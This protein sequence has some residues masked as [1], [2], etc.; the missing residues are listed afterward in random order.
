MPGNTCHDRAV[1]VRGTCP[2]CGQERALPGRRPGD[3]ALICTDCAG[4][5][6]SVACSR[7]GCEDKLHRGRLCSRCTLADQVSA[8]LDDGSGQIRPALVPLA[9]SLLA[10]DRPRS[11]LGWLS[12]RK[13]QPG[14]AHDLLRRLGRGEIELTHEAFL[15]L[16][17]PQAATHLRE[18]LMACGVLPPL[19]R[20]VW[21]FEQWLPGHLAALPDQGHAQLIR[22][23]ATWDVLPRLRAGAERKPLTPATRRYAGEQVKAATAFLQ[24]LAGRDTAPASCRQADIDAWYADD[25]RP[26]RALVRNFVKWCIATRLTGRLRLPSTITRHAAPLSDEER[27]FH[28]GRVLTDEDLPLRTRIASVFLLLYAQPCSR[29]VRL[30]LDD[31]TRDGDQ[32]LLRLGDPPVPL[33]G[34]VASL[35]AK[36]IS[37]RD[38]MNTATNRNSPWLFPG[39]GAGQPMTANTLAG[40]VTGIGVPTT[41]GRAS[42]IRQHVMEMPASVVA[43]ALGY[44]PDT[45]TRLAA[46]AG[47]TFSRYAPGDHERPSPVR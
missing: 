16:E 26:G 46:R 23:F 40:H 38:K 39:R 20:Q 3:E 30:T 2:G 42:A 36:W 34:P 4:F 8:L 33:P 10:M 35:L 6:R 31:V 5:S 15:G 32:V 1:Q 7:C 17:S 19:D 41:A 28:L 29:I 43:D 25:S 14:S 21:L 18:L 45:T 44:R 12:M 37:C 9:D 22:R 47:S 24:W 27:T 11:G 13:D